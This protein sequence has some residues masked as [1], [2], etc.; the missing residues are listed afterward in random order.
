MAVDERRGSGRRGVSARR[1][2]DESDRYDASL[3]QGCQAARRPHLRE[4]TRDRHPPTRR[5]RDRRCDGAGRHSGRDRR[6]LRRDVGARGRAAG[7]G[8]R[9]AACRG[10]FLRGDRGGARTRLRAAHAARPGQRH[11]FQGGGRLHSGRLFRGERQAVGQGR[12]GHSGRFRLR[13]VRRGLGAS[14]RR[15][16]QSHAP[17]AGAGDRGHQ[18]VSER[19]GEFH[20]RRPLPS[21]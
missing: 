16:P 1:R 12:D 9:A 15:V 3:R 7:R 11:V 10:A 18:A 17:Y 19:A 20:A 21:G 5:V 2:P 13:H 4:R 14:G 6:Q 8:Q